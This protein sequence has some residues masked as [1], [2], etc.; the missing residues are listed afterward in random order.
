MNGKLRD[1]TM[2]RDGT[3]NVTVTVSGDFREEYDRLAGKELDIEIRLHRQRRSL[4]A[5]A[6][7]WV[8]AGKIAES[9]HISREEVYRNAIRDIG[10]ASETVCVQDKAVDSLRAAWSSHGVGWQTETMPSKIQGCT[11]VLLYY[12]SSVY[13]TRQMSQLIDH[14]VQDAEALGIETITP[15]RKEELL[16]G[17]A[18]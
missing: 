3:Q 10:G 17:W 2:N 15:A 14:L 8:I 1:L 11:N 6:Y 12:G 5:N 7:C 4:D 13:D 18:R 9:M 16:R